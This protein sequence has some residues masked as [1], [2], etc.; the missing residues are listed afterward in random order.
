MLAGMDEVDVSG[1]RLKNAPK[2]ENGCWITLGFK[3][4]LNLCTDH[5]QN[6]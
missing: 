2:V 5:S 3:I 1:P 4:F 6:H